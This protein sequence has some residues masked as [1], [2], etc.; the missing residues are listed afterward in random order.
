[1]TPIDKEQGG[2]LVA[3]LE[4]S[5]HIHMNSF[6]EKSDEKKRRDRT[7][8]PRDHHTRRLDTQKAIPLL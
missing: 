6:F 5:D 8:K 2:V 4:A 3:T 7:G 1:M